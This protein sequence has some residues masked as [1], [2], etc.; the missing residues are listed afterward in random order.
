MKEMM[1]AKIVIA[2]A[3]I[4][5]FFMSVRTDSEVLR[6]IGIGL[7]AVAFLLRFVGRKGAP[8]AK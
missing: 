3:G 1:V 5:V 4:A 2:L 8:A 7:V 6:W